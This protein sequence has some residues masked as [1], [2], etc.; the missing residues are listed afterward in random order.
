M[1]LQTA[2]RVFRWGQW[3]PPANSRFFLGGCPLSTENW[4]TLKKRSRRPVEQRQAQNS[5]CIWTEMQR[6][7]ANLVGRVKVVE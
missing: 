7:R 5:L 1:F 2:K 6:V 4:A 3:L